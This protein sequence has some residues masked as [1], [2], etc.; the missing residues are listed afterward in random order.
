MESELKDWINKQLEEGKCI[1]SNPTNSNSL[2]LSN[3]IH[4]TPLNLSN[5]AQAPSTNVG[6]TTIFGPS[7]SV[8]LSTNDRIQLPKKRGRKTGSLNKKPSKK[9]TSCN[10]TLN[11]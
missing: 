11:M 3:P 10:D 4:S 7:A 1:L 5:P 9:K 2:I 6:P 8:A